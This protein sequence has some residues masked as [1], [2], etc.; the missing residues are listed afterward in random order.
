LLSLHRRWQ[1]RA[2]GHAAGG[3]VICGPQDTLFGRN[4]IGGAMNMTIQRPT[5]KLDMRLVADHPQHDGFGKTASLDQLL[6][7]DKRD[8]RHLRL[9]AKPVEALDVDLYLDRFRS[10]AHLQVWVLACLD[11]AVASSRQQARCAAAVE[12]QPFKLRSSPAACSAPL[13]R[14]RPAPPPA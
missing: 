9:L 5:H 12:S 10:S 11:P 1:H 13:G 7:E 3:G 14:L 2:G 8:Y 4:T 6:G